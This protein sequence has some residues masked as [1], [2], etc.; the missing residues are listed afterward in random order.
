LPNALNDE[1]R[2]APDGL[3]D[4]LQ[5]YPMEIDAGQFAL[6][7]GTVATIDGTGVDPSALQVRDQRG[8][9]DV[10]KASSVTK[11]RHGLTFE[12]I[13]DSA[14]PV[15]CDFQLK[16]DGPNKD[17][18]FPKLFPTGGGLNF[19]KLYYLPW[20]ADKRHA[21]DLG[22]AADF[23]MTASMHGCRFEVHR[24]P[25][26]VYHVS[27]SN[28]QPRADATK[29]A[30]EM[31]AYLRRADRN[32]GTRSLKFGKDKYFA[33]A[34]RLMGSAQH[35]MILWGIPPEDVLEAEPQTYKA[36]V[37]GRR[38]GARDWE[39][40]YQLWGW[41]KVRLHERVQKKKWL[42]L[43]TGYENKTNESYLKVV[44]LVE[45]IYPDHRVLFELHNP[46]A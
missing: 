46:P 11:A 19:V 5:T 44:Y 45:K 39:F 23:F 4:F 34:Q 29:G 40:Y 9:V 38:V 2:A 32:R 13:Q 22:G 43:R 27:H 18:V 37:V 20:D 16:T 21:M 26:H 15:W 1:F 14:T 33:D 30:Q 10:L 28:V 36:N 7:P 42:G 8:V 12:V 17:V 41:V 3:T 25:G 31:I 35:R 6:L 24:K